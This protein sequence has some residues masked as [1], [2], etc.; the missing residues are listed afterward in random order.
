MTD[1][2]LQFEIMT[3]DLGGHLDNMSASERR[4]IFDALDK[5]YCLFCG[6][7]QHESG[8]C[9]WCGKFKDAHD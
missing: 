1:N 4:E 2:P 3:F 8:V 9:S 7:N 6:G 5:R